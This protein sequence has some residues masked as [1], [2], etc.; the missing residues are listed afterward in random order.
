MP[1]EN[2]KPWMSQL[3]GDLQNNAFFTR[4][5]SVS[6]VGKFALESEGKLQEAEGK[7]KDAVFIPGADAKPEEWNP[8][9]Q[10]LGKPE[11]VEDYP[12]QRPEGWPEGIPYD[13]EGEKWFR[14]IAL[15]NN[16]TKAQ[17]QGLYSDYMNF[18]I[19]GSKSLRAAQDKAKNDA[20]ESLK[21]E[22]GAEWQSNLTLM[23]RA[24]EAYGSPE[25]KKHLDETG[26]GNH[27]EMIKIFVKIGKAMAED[28]FSGGGTGGGDKDKRPGVLSYPS[29][30]G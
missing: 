30:Q 5:E 29:M 12:V 20:L 18:Y 17:A 22:W 1:L 4:F 7:L 23:N 9:Y 2:A 26:L 27:P 6:D 19:E 13:A 8:I 15:K 28:K 16:L 3:Q 25:F 14:G 11:K 24:L 10:K 21:K